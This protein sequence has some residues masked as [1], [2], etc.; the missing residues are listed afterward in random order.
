MLQLKGGPERIQAMLRLPEYK[1][2]IELHLAKTKAK[3]PDLK[4]VEVQEYANTEEKKQ[5][6][7]CHMASVQLMGQFMD[8]LTHLRRGRALEVAAG[9]GR[10]AKDV[11]SM[12]FKTVDCF[13]QCIEAVKELEKLRRRLPELDLVDQAKM[14]SYVY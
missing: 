2:Q 12:R 6:A 3:R 9:D 4:P 14:Q 11:L 10:V 13:D 5:M 7:E 1:K 8:E